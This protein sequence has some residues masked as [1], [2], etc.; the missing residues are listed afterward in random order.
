MTDTG[1]IEKDLFKD[2]CPRKEDS[3]KQ[4]KG[5]KGENKEV[6]TERLPQGQVEWVNVD[7]EM[8]K[9]KK[10]E[11][12]EKRD[13]FWF[14]VL[15]AG[16]IVIA[17]FIIIYEL[18]ESLWF[19]GCPRKRKN[20]YR[21]MMQKRVTEAGSIRP[22]RFDLDFFRNKDSVI[23]HFSSSQAMY[24]SCEVSLYVP[25]D[26]A[27]GY[28]KVPWQDML[29]LYSVRVPNTFHSY[30]AD[31][32]VS[33]LIEHGWLRKFQQEYRLTDAVPV[34]NYSFK[35]SC[36][37]IWYK[38][39]LE[40]CIHRE[41]WDEDVKAPVE[42]FVELL[43]R[44]EPVKGT[45]WVPVGYRCCPLGTFTLERGCFDKLTGRSRRRLERIL[46]GHGVYI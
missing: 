17:P 31:G 15:V 35:N 7:R 14:K 22:D 30:W 33:N 8:K 46:E 19:K 4:Q 26:K 37:V 21:N 43:S 28:P 5:T 18:A 23:L 38:R 6:W 42:C 45:E 9:A 32:Y 40:N 25:E 36:D 20:E 11:E 41:L 16:L 44:V 39:E 34:I 27:G 24:P 10:E 3:S 2:S 13:E 12:T 1:K 29:T